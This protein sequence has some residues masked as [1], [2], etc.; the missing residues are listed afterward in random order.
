MKY[1]RTFT[2]LEDWVLD[3]EHQL[4]CKIRKLRPQEVNNILMVIL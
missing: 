2:Y 1:V 3:D 4:Y